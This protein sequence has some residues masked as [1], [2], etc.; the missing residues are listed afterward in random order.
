MKIEN[1]VLGMSSPPSPMKVAKASS[2]SANSSC[3]PNFSAK[4]ASGGAARVNSTT[5]T[6]PPMKEAIAAAMR[7][8][9]PLPAMASGLPSKT[10]ATA[11]DAPGMPRVMEEMAPPYMAP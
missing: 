4:A 6:V 8:W 5:D 9:S 2:I 11:V 10:V 7:A 1:S 3:G